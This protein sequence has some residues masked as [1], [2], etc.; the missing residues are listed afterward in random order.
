[1]RILKS[2]RNSFYKSFE[3]GNSNVALLSSTTTFGEM[4]NPDAWLCIYAR[5][6]CIEFV[7][8]CAPYG[9]QLCMYDVWPYL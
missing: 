3:R 7:H 8:G 2:T 1:M 6:H 5:Q 9:T 4:K